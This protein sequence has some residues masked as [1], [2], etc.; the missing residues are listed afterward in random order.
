[1]KKFFYISLFLVSFTYSVAQ[2]TE[3]VNLLSTKLTKL[4]SE[5]RTIDDRASILR[6]SIRL[7]EAKINQE[8]LNELTTQGFICV[9]QTNSE[10]NVRD[11]PAIN[12]HQIF[13]IPKKSD[14]KV[15]EFM[16]SAYWKIQ[17]ENKIGFVNDVFLVKTDEMK[18]AEKSGPQATGPNLTPSTN[19]FSTSTSQSTYPS[20]TQSSYNTGAK[21]IHTGPRGGRY[22][23]SNSGKKVYE[24]KKK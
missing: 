17:Y 24:K 15:L 18:L 16:G 14:I 9:T 20:S 7:L 6:D 23:Y 13:S 21:T 3:K 8:K 10:A 19:S 4:A 12:G 22:H 2:E 1:M 5:L 11:N